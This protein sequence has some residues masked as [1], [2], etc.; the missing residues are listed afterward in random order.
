MSKQIIIDDVQN[1]KTPDRKKAT[2]T[3][4]DTLPNQE[5]KEVINIVNVENNKTLER[6]EENYTNNDTLPE[7]TKEE[8]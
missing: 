7:E 3:N 4:S 2:D 5:I 8:N 6:K 1:D